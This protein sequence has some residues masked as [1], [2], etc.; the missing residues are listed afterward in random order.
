ME[1]YGSCEI[2]TEHE[3]QAEP[4]KTTSRRSTAVMRTTSNDDLPKYCVVLKKSTKKSTS[5]DVRPR[6]LRPLIKESQIWSSNYN[7]IFVVV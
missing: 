1:E 6:S 5:R 3:L 4:T 2:F 7:R